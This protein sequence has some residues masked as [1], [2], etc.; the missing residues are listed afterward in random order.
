MTDA[1]KDLASVAVLPELRRALTVLQNEAE[2]ATRSNAALS[3]FNSIMAATSEAEVFDAAE[4]GTTASKD[5]V[6]KAFRLQ[7]YDIKWQKS[8]AQYTEQGSFP[9]YT[10]LTVT[11]MEDGEQKVINCGSP[12]VIATLLRL[13]ELEDDDTVAEKP[14]KP[15]EAD[16]GK[17]MQ[18]VEKAA[19]SGNNVI[20]IKPVHLQ[21]SNVKKRV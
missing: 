8:A 20:L 14:F 17:P 18:F 11:D 5:F 1:G 21:P 12:S 3:I 15:F 16:G 10:L 19:A 2:A 7:R 6:N 4:A 9:F 13:S